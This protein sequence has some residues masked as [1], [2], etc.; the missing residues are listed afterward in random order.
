MDASLIAYLAFFLTIA[1]TY[2]IMT[3]GLNVQ[4]GLTGVFNVGVAGFVLVGAYT[5]SILTTPPIEGRVGGFDLPMAVG[6]LAAMLSAAG[7]SLL[8]GALTLRLRA[9]YLAI[10]TFGFAVVV[11]LAALNLEWLTGGPFGITFIP[12]PFGADAGDALTFGLSNL[13]LVAAV[14]AAVAILLEQLK[15][16]PWGRVLR[17][18][19]EDEDAA[20][21]L[22]KNAIRFRLQAFALGGAVMGLAGA[23]GAHFIGFIAPQNYLAILT[24]QVWAMLIVGGSGSNLGAIIGAVAVWAL[25]SL[26]AA[27]VEWVFPPGAQARAASLQIVFIGIGLCAILLVRPRG[28]VGQRVAVMRRGRDRERDEAR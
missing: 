27:A 6:W 20:R 25:W 16:S 18:I 2:A 15:R 17:A 19:R 24:F 22:G 10:A 3:L 26:S 12:R 8:V 14:V 1:L 23:V 13:A 11:H 5:S 9:D 28:I 7:M 21:S 4:W